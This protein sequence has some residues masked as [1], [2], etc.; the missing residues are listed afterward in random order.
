[1][2][3]V[4]T[5]LE[6]IEWV[7]TRGRELNLSFKAGSPNFC[8]AARCA[9]DLAPKEIPKSRVQSFHNR[10]L[11]FGRLGQDGEVL[12][13]HDPALAEFVQQFDVRYSGKIVDLES[14]LQLMR[15]V[16][17]SFD[18]VLEIPSKVRDLI[19]AV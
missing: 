6:V 7:D 19:Q 1:M 10:S 4:L 15:A 12:F 17:D 14:T 16:L 11:V 13:R 8:V 5:L 18:L 9:Q 2:S 3:R